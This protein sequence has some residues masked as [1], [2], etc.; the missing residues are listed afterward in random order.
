M[1]GRPGRAGRDCRAVCDRRWGHDAGHRADATER[2]HG[3]RESHEGRTLALGGGALKMRSDPPPGLFDRAP[4]ERLERDWERQLAGPAIAGHFEDWRRREPMLRAFSH[5]RALIRHLRAAKAGGRTDALLLAL[6]RIAHDD[7]LAAQLLLV[8]LMPGV[9]SAVAQYPAPLH[10][11]YHE[12]L[13]SVLFDLLWR[14]IRT[15]EVERLTHGVATQIIKSCVRDAH[16]EVEKEHERAETMEADLPEDYPVFAQEEVDVDAVLTAAVRARAITQREAEVI[17][18]SRIDGASLEELAAKDGK[19]YDAL[20]L[21]RRRA[22]RRLRAH[23]K[24]MFDSHADM[25]SLQSRG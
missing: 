5:P 4:L 11:R 9:K 24:S 23:V 7:E 20:R 8:R 25:A 10:A 6:L 18:L 1:E 16:R 14:K 12:E 13:W 15:Y 3:L 17:A 22:E 2:H 21:F 19:T